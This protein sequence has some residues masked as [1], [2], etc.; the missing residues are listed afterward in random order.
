MRLYRRDL[1]SGLYAMG[2]DIIQAYRANQR[3]LHADGELRALFAVLDAA[4][5]AFAANRPRLPGEG[6]AGKGTGRAVRV[7]ST[8]SAESVS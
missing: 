3:M 8:K 4:D 1:R 5:P 2:S 6:P 7:A